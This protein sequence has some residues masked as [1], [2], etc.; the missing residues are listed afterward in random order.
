MQFKFI[1]IYIY[2]CL[3]KHQSSV[4][5]VYVF[6]RIFGHFMTPGGNKISMRY[7]TYNDVQSL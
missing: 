5:L 3:L 4:G 1:Y 7:H 6:D 2:W